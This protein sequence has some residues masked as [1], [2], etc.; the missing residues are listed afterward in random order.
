MTTTEPTL[1]DDTQADG[2]SMSDETRA[3]LIAKAAGDQGI[4]AAEASAVRDS[5][6]AQADLGGRKEDTENQHPSDWK[7]SEETRKI[8]R[9]G[10]AEARSVLKAIPPRE[11]KTK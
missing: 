2:P 10:I 6:S 3:S 9:H 11:D 4:R 5:Q 7:L 1:F 8:G